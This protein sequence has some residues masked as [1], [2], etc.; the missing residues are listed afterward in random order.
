MSYY[1]VHAITIELDIG[2]RAGF[3]LR[4]SEFR[5]EA[6]PDYFQEEGVG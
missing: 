1:A 6:N 3:N 5:S 2:Q 4:Q